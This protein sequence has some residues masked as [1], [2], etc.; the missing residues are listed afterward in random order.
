MLIGLAG[1]AGV[2]Q[3]VV[4]DYL[5][6]THAF[7]STTLITDD[8][9]DELAD[10]QVVVTTI[11]DRADADRLADRGGVLVYLCDPQLPH[12]GPENGIALRDVD[13]AVEVTCDFF[14]VFDLLDR[15]I[16]EA[17]FLGESV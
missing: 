11:R 9:V 8:L 17:E 12:L 10:H 14:R 1:R 7:T 4:A 13:H 3:D 16:G 6:Q 2:G 15:V 5:T